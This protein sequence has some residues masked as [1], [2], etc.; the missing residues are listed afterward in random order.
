MGQRPRNIFFALVAAMILIRGLYWGYF[1]IGISLLEL[2][3]SIL[4]GRP[5]IWF[6]DQMALFAK[7]GENSDC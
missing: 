5:A 6:F 2:P 3:A 1:G 7:V 4:L